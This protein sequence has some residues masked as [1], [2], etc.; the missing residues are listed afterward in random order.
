L[1]EEKQSKNEAANQIS[2]KESEIEILNRNIEKLKKENKDF[3]NQ[4][5]SGL[6]RL[7]YQKMRI[8]VL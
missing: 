4:V 6:I 5:N 7:N 3:L 2:V 1:E 8:K